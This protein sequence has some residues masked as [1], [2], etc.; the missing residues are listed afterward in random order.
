MAVPVYAGRVAPLALERLRRFRG[1]SSPAILL[2]VYGNRDYED[3]LVELRDVVMDLGFV[4]LAAG[5]FVGE[6][7]YSRRE[8]PIA[9]GRPDD[10]DLA[11]A[12]QFGE[13]ALSKLV[14]AHDLQSVYPFYMKMCLTVKYLLLRR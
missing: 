10:A 13:K 12:C 2:V 1:N 11:A 4:P 6:H 3:A 14:S 5:A 9:E 8:M 7:S